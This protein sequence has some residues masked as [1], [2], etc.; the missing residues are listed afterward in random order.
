MVAV[1]QPLSRL[2]LISKKSALDWPLSVTRQCP[3]EHS[4]KRR[5]RHEE[6]GAKKRMATEQSASISGLHAEV[7]R[8][9][10][11]ALMRLAPPVREAVMLQRSAYP[12]IAFE[13]ETSGA[14]YRLRI[15]ATE[16]GI[17]S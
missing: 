16:Q 13:I 1:L 4:L 6:K 3:R 9:L 8:E 15:D 17:R 2:A 14:A 12:H 5:S 7:A 11:E 10:D